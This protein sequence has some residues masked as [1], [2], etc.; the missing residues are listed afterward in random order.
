MDFTSLSFWFSQNTV[1]SVANR[2]EAFLTNN[3]LARFFLIEKSLN[4]IF[5]IS[6]LNM[7]YVPPMTSLFVWFAQIFKYV[8]LKQCFPCSRQ[9]NNGLE[10][11]IRLFY[12]YLFT[13]IY[14]EFILFHAWQ[15]CF[16]RKN[17]LFARAATLSWP[18]MIIYSQ[19][20]KKVYKQAIAIQVR[21]NKITQIP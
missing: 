13:H 20:R 5:W 1:L 16:R 8:Y 7:S 18:N 2:R 6:Y 4:V 12:I 21:C 14:S 19:C 17:V 3:V 9:T 15:F 11:F 10:K